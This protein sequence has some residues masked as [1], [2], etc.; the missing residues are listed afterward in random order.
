M[1]GRQINSH[2]SLVSGRV[3]TKLTIYYKCILTEF[4]DICTSG[5]RSREFQLNMLSKWRTSKRQIE[6]SAWERQ[7]PSVNVTYITLPVSQHSMSFCENKNQ[8]NAI[9]KHQY[10]KTW[11]ISCGPR[12]WQAL[13]TIIVNVYAPAIAKC[14]QENLAT[15]DL[16]PVS[17]KQMS[18]AY[19]GIGFCKEEA[20]TFAQLLLHWDHGFLWRHK[21]PLGF[22]INPVLYLVSMLT[23]KN[24]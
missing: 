16:Q 4:E 9:T 24:H 3:N 8:K 20:K 19:G 11:K 7:A 14:L 2:G 15:P 22:Q 10:L 23:P 18:N 21:F 6:R 17:N 12:I 5:F 1:Y 13:V